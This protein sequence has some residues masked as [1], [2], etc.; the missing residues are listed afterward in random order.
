MKFF[1]I[2]I[3]IVYF[4]VFLYL[5][6]P[7]FW[8][9]LNPEWTLCSKG[10]HQ[11]PINIE[12]RTLLFDPNLK[13]IRI[14]KHRVSSTQENILHTFVQCVRCINTSCNINLLNLLNSFDIEQ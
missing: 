13:H 1:C 9:R 14:D 11:S 7:K 10:K 3:K 5:S 2:I 6:G 4:Y 8:G 12:P